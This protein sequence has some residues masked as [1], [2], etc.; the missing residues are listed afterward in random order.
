MLYWSLWLFII[1]V[2]V[3]DSFLT[4]VFRSDMKT[5]EL[6]PIGRWL[7]NLNG[8]DVVLLLVAKLA[9]TIVVTS[10][11]A[12]FY[13]RDPRKAFAITTPISCF[14]MWLLLFLTFG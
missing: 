4:F 9:G 8:G 11:L 6:N 2:S 7:I 13:E 14:Q 5:S 1:F 3:W 10:L 12:V